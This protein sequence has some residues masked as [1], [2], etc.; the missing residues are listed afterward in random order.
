M[1]SIAS[2]HVTH[3]WAAIE[4]LE[5]VTAKEARSLLAAVRALPAVREAVIL[6]TCN[7]VEVYAAVSGPEGQKSLEAIAA[8]LLP[9]ESEGAI[10]FLEGR[11]SVRQLFRV[12]GGLDSMIVGEDQILGQV[13]EAME[14][15][16]E[17]GAL[18]PALDRLFRKAVSAGKRVRTETRVNEGAVSIGSAAV[19][20]AVDLLGDLT[21]KVVLVLGAGEMATLVGKA[22]ARWK[23]KAIFVANRSQERA[24]ELARE[25]GGIAI[26]F[27]EMPSY[28]PVSDVIISAVGAPH[29]VL[30]KEELTGMLGKSARV[31]PLLVIDIGNPR[32]IDEGVAE[33]PGVDLRNLDGLQKIAR[34]NLERRQGEVLAAERIVEEEVAAFLGK[35]DEAPAEAIAK[36]LYTKMRDLRDEEYEELLRKV[37]GLSPEHREALRAMLDSF[38]NR[39]LAEPTLALKRAAREGDLA[40]LRIA[41]RL[42]GL[43][44]E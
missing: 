14:F 20:L 30:N 3:R 7:R 25:L 40:S 43:E 13:K 19:D 44:E 33:L 12:A 38:A 35:A 1:P 6:K 26:T 24:T 21:G 10:R 2:A 31:E 16:R 18:G 34:E 32:T 11:E 37:D 4:Q 36:R 39:L 29:F 8:N 28:V 23:L 15:A 27:E 17:E 41:A 42:F 22:L 9:H 5:L